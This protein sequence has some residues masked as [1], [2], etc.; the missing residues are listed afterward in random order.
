M[1]PNIDLYDILSCYMNTEMDF[2]AI[3]KKIGENVPVVKKNIEER[4]VADLKE[5]MR[6][7]PNEIRERRILEL[8]IELQERQNKIF[9]ESN[10]VEIFNQ[11]R[12]QKV[13]ILSN[14][15]VYKEEE[16]NIKMSFV[17]K[18][19]SGEKTETVKTKI[20]DFKPAEVSSQ[21]DKDSAY[22]YENDTLVHWRT[23]GVHNHFFRTFIRSNN[24]SIKF[25]EDCRGISRV[26]AVVENGLL[27]IEG[28]KTY[29]VDENLDL[30]TAIE[31]AIAEPF[32]ESKYSGPVDGGSYEDG[33][34][35]QTPAIRVRFD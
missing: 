14:E 19:L 1:Y 16:K 23:Q 2:S 12:D 9:E 5:K 6:T 18:L 17:R 34:D 7:D 4:R 35:R 26:T 32:V 15:P 29:I 10:V 13:L 21:P 30:I 22:F 33:L 3:A 11:L 8:W 20:S 24:V 27:K 28:K 31:K 25:N